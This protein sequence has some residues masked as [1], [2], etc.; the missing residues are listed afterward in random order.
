MQE[1]PRNVNR[2]VVV[3]PTTQAWP[4]YRDHGAYACQPG[5]T[6]RSV[7]HMAFYVD[8][9]V[10]VQVPAI[11]K[12]IGRVAWTLDQIE[13]RQKAGTDLDKRLAALIRAGHASGWTGDEY[14]VFLL[15][16][17][18]ADASTD[19]VVLPGKLTHNRRGRGSAWVQRQRYVSLERLRTATTLEETIQN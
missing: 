4:F 13:A 17:P 18:G 3:V 9:A 16:P 15:T 7:S 12:K 10:Q 8:G 2:V 6:F 11:E 1:R 19:H 5:R 14:E